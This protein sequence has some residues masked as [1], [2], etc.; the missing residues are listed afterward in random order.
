[1]L[2]ATELAPVTVSVATAAGV[3]VIPLWVPLTSGLEVSVAVIDCGPAVFSVTL[4]AF[5]P[6]SVAMN[7]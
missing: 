6:L 7:V 5:W 2:L 1:M 3:T 4:R